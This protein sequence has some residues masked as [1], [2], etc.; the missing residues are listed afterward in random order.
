S[1]LE[2]YLQLEEDDEDDDGFEP[3]VWWA[4]RKAEFAALSQMAFNVLSIPA[5]S[6]ECERVFSQGKLTMSSQRRMKS[7]TLELL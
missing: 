4:A 3:L 5:M 6:S 7:S 1:E 2:K